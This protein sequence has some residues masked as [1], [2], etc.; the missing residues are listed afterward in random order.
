AG[1]SWSEAARTRLDFFRKEGLAGLP[2]CMAKTPLSLSHDPAV[3]GRPEGFVLPITNV[4]VAAGA[5]WI[6]PLAGNIM[7]MPG[8][9]RRPA[10]EGIDLDDEGRVHGLF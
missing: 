4:R 2:I 3:K 8:L 5:G 7:T 10:A 9:P 1:V 6:Y